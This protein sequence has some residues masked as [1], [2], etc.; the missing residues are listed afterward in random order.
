[1]RLPAGTYRVTQTIY[2][3]KGVVLRGDG[4]ATTHVEGDRVPDWAILHLGEHWDESNT[5]IT[6]GAAPLLRLPMSGSRCSGRSDRGVVPDGNI[7]SR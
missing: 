6:P 1:M 7:P 2:L 3:L 4:P 5:P